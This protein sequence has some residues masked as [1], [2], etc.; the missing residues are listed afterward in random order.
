MILLVMTM[1]VAKIKYRKVDRFIDIV[2]RTITGRINDECWGSSSREIYAALVSLTVV[3][4]PPPL[5]SACS[6]FGALSSQVW[7]CYFKVSCN[8]SR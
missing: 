1:P 6:G 3:G 5:N 4:I 8:Q 2:H 7:N